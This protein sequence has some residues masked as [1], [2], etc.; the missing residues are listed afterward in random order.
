MGKKEAV[1]TGATSF[2]GSAL[3]KY[4]LKKGFKVFAVARKESKNIRTLPQHPNLHIIWAS[5]G[6]ID[7]I[8]DQIPQDSVFIHFA[9]AGVGSEGRKDAGIQAYNICCS[10]NALTTAMKA[11]CRRFI[12]AGSQAEYGVHHERISENTK[13]VP[14]SEYGK[15]KLEFGNWA[16]GA[17]ANE[18][19]EYIHLRI[20]SIYGEGD[21]P[22]TLVKS[23]I[24][25]FT[26]GG[27]ILLGPCEQK[28]NFLY[29]DDAVD[30]LFKI[31]E[32]ERHLDIYGAIYNV[33]GDDIRPLK[34]FVLEMYDIC[35]RKGNFEFGTGNVKAE[36]HTE[37]IP[38]IQK[39]STLFDWRPA[40]DFKTG[41]QKMVT[42]EKRGMK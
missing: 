17:C 13:C 35:G 4:L 31:I 29:I 24:R 11:N 25:A 26:E 10:K 33:A 8:V 41:I 5:L 19:M 28:W 40:V 16:R 20:F 38:D 14:V 3:V 21:H 30:I 42:R 39:I 6:E 2:L 1:I 27:K 34:E 37:L 36:G 23:C 7:K 9:W 22:W 32:D 18:K 15:A 12:F